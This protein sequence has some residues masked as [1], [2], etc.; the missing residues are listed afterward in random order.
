[1]ADRPNNRLPWTEVVSGISASSRERVRSARRFFEKR[2]FAANQNLEKRGF[3]RSLFDAV[4]DENVSFIDIAQRVV[5]EIRGKQEANALNVCV[6]KVTQLG[7]EGWFRSSGR[8]ELV[9]NSANLQ[10]SI[11]PNE[12]LENVKG[13]NLLLYA[14]FRRSPPL[15]TDAIRGLLNLIGR[16]SEALIYENA[17]IVILDCY[18]DR[19]FE[20]SEFQ[21][22][23]LWIS[24]Q[25]NNILSTYNVTF[26]SHS[27]GDPPGLG[28]SY[29]ALTSSVGSR[30]N[31]NFSVTPIQNQ[32]CLPFSMTFSS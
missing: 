32:L 16:S 9:V 18:N 13:E 30:P 23:E 11:H 5:D 1:M 24:K 15:S 10:I 8:V 19:S 3:I 20:A 7:E 17:R 2:R 27:D 29:P 4:F 21:E 31:A 14:Y 25:I 28:N 26:Q 12:F 6:E 22:G